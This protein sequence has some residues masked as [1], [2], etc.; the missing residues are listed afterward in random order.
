[1]CPGGIACVKLLS[2][3]FCHIPVFIP[4]RKCD[5]VLVEVCVG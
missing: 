5:N 3:F 2:V 4:C 1:M